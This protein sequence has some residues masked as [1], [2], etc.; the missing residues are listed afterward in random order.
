MGK[1]L[2]THYV[3][4][5]L[6][7]SQKKVNTDHKRSELQRKSDNVPLSRI[8]HKNVCPEFCGPCSGIQKSNLLPPSFALTLTSFFN[9][10]EPPL[11]VNSQDKETQND[12][13]GRLHPAVG[14]GKHKDEHAI[15]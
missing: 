14:S 8:L 5:R 13:N 9:E 12:G 1:L 2:Y 11:A 3:L 4:S 10:L 6:G 7:S 15:S